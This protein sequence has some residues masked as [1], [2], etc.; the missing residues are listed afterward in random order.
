MVPRSASASAAAR[1]PSALPC[2]TIPRQE[3]RAQIFEDIPRGERIFFVKKQDVGGITYSDIYSM[4]STGGDVRPVTHFSENL[5][6]VD[7]PD[8]SQ[9]GTRLAFLSNDRSWA[10]AFHMDAF[11]MDLASSA[12]TRITGDE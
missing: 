9:D 5:A 4:D 2:D 7:F 6:V 3:G 11:L 12:M 10:S 8:I 1:L